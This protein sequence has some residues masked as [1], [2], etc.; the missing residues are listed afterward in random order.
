MK[1][2]NVLRFC[3]FALVSILLG[4]DKV[5]AD[6]NCTYGY[7]P[8]GSNTWEPQ[9][10]LKV[11]AWNRITLSSDSQFVKSRKGDL[12]TCG[13]G[14]ECDYKQHPSEFNI[15]V[16]R[17]GNWLALMS[18]MPLAT[19]INQFRNESFTLYRLG[20]Y[21]NQEAYNIYER[22]GN[23]CPPRVQVCQSRS[24][25]WP[26]T[27]GGTNLPTITVGIF[28]D[29]LVKPDME[30]SGW[31]W[32]KIYTWDEG[33]ITLNEESKKDEPYLQNVEFSSCSTYDAYLNAMNSAKEDTGTCDNNELFQ[34]YYDSITKICD[35]YMSSNSYAGSLS[36]DTSAKACMTACSHLKDDIVKICDYDINSQPTKKCESIGE[37]LLAWIFKIFN[38]MRYIVPAILILLGI[39]DFI[40]AIASDSEDELKKVG[41]RFAK[42]LVAAGLIFLVPLILQFVLGL[43]DIPGLDPNNPFCAL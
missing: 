1:K 25:D 9:V 21:A 32:A 26:W 23:V 22:Q 31:S 14:E 40:K 36:G 20:M 8:S 5:F 41:S 34:G 13:S 15:F 17:A 33:C 38:W 29:E 4:T 42:R 18:G 27:N 37:K 19:F 11:E 24:V 28:T 6:T 3:L 39:T 30:D 35:K 7:Y 2:N 10:E 43:F 12:D 16:T